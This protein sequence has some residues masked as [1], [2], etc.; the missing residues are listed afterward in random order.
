MAVKN[1]PRP[2]CVKEVRSFLGFSSYYRKFIK[3]FETIAKPLVKLSEK[4][5]KFSWKDECEGSFNIL[6]GVM[7]EAPV[8]A[9][10]DMTKTFILDTDASGV[11]VGA[12]LSQMY[13]GKE[14]V[15][16]YFSILLSKTERRYCVTRCELLAVVEAVKHFHHYLYGVPLC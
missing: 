9:Y 16:G 3:D 2:S 11:G 1:W 13:D 10:P 12:V 4:N 14:R 8:L 7:T 15:I 6:K 5:V